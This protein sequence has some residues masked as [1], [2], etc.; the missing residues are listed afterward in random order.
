MPDAFLLNVS[1]YLL[2]PVTTKQVREQLDILRFPV[3]ALDTEKIR[4][5]C[6]GNFDA[7]FR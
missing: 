7:F 1:G 5:Q 3:R 6:F 4:L 2:K